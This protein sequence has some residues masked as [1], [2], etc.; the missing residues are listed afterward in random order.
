MLRHAFFIPFYIDINKNID[1]LQKNKSRNILQLRNIK[2][3]TLVRYINGAGSGNRTVKLFIFSFIAHN[4]VFMPVTAFLRSS[5]FPLLSNL[6]LIN[7]L[8]NY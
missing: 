4:P 6:V 5:Y 3:S 2:A 7:I 8:I 1:K